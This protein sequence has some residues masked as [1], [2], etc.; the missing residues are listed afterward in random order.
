MKQA[1]LPIRFFARIVREKPDLVHINTA[2]TDLSIWR[3]AALLRAAKLAGR[4][5]ALSIHGGKFLV[6]EFDDP[7]LER[8]TTRMLRASK[9]VIVYSDLEQREVERRWS[10][11]NIKV[12][13]N[14]V[15]S[16]SQRSQHAKTPKPVIIFFG[17]LHESKGLEEIVKAVR[18]LRAENIGFQFNCFGDGPMKDVFLQQMRQ[19]LGDAFRYGG[20]VTSDEKWT[21]FAAADIF[22]LPS[23]YGEGLP[24]AILE[25]MA[26]GCVVVASEMASVASVIDD[27]VNGYL[28]EPRNTA[29]LVDRLKKIIN[30]PSSWQPMTERRK[31]PS[32]IALQYPITSRN[33]KLS[34]KKLQPE[35]ENLERRDRVRVVSLD[36]DVV[37][38]AAAIERVA[39]LAERGNG[40][41]VCFG[42]VHMIME[43]H[44]SPAF[45]E[46]VNAADMI[47][48][49]GMPLVWMQR[50]QGRK[51]AQRVRA[52]DLMIL[53]C[54]YAE[55]HGLSVGFY[56]GRQ[57]VVDAI[58]ERAA[59]DFPGL[60]VAYAYS[61]PF[62]PLTSEEDA[63][64]DRRD[65]T[66]R[67]ADPLYGPRLPETGKLDGVAQIRG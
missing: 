22:L 29:Q 43:S 48:P 59:K 24:M 13:P 42:T 23:I 62:R 57:E 60:N 2:L 8:V 66:V 17:R 64:S 1:V 34:I 16:L 54:G 33:S 14:A 58:V 55:K 61:P 19:A 6:N 4:P 36:A 39:A 38:H 37:D 46:I 40:A 9:A 45:G 25:A 3:D 51:T 67:R 15:P 28:V 47:V 26:A 65:R 18:A 50:L 35:P 32:V 30:D 27:G 11:L 5:V 44:D 10:G 7:R 12:L 31:R 52:N 21:Q 49:D 56:G 63:R 41:Y 53:L 20:V